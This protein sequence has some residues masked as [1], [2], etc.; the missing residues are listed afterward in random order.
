M[1][2]TEKLLKQFNKPDTILFISKY[3]FENIAPSYHGV[4]TYTEHLINEL[5]RYTKRKCVVLVE[6]EYDRPV[7]T[8]KKGQVLILPAFTQ[9]LMMFPELLTTIQQFT[10]IK[11]IHVHSEFFTSGKIIPMAL[12]IPFFTSLRVLGK[13]INYTA[14]NVITDFSFMA[15]HLGHTQT[16]PF[17]KL[18]EYGLPFYY[19][20]LGLSVNRMIALDESIVQRLTQHVAADKLMLSPHW[21]FPQ[22]PSA[23]LRTAWRKK[24][25]YSKDNIVIT[26][27]GFM[28][29]Y[30]GIDWLLPTM[31]QL[32]KTRQFKHIKLLFA[33]GRAPSQEGK[34]HY[35]SFYRAFE[36]TCRTTKGVHLTGFIAEEDIAGYM[37]AS[38][39]VILPYRG[40][41]GASGSWAHALAQGK[42]TLLA[43]DLEVYLHGQDAQTALAEAGLAATDLIFTRHKVSLIQKLAQLSDKNY[44]KK[45]AKF[46]ARL[47]Q[48]R[49]AEQQLP[50]ELTTL[51]TSPEQPSPLEWN[52]VE[53]LKKAFVELV[54]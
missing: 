31:T 1:K 3:P 38:D 44:L 23:A 14:H 29:R 37:A 51:Y 15:R 10:A 39:V 46:S 24:L 9:G 53:K 47:A 32:Q 36:K 12:C 33:G 16:S 5:T 22:Q 27:F 52:Y 17:L 54:A 2:L 21:V 7:Q 43:S 48:L 49:T 4:A 8:L 25:G 18:M 11:D 34:A 40:V 13:R 6:S 20:F 45:L 19:K 26:C 41:L 42:P 50:T 30:K 28:T 35:E